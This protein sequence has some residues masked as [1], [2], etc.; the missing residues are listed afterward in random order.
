MATVSA[1][2]TSL[3]YDLRDYSEHDF[4][5]P[6]LIEYLNR[7]I[8]QLDSALLSMDSDWLYRTGTAVLSSGQNKITQPT[9][10]ISIRSMWVSSILESYT[11]LTFAASG[12]TIT[13]AALADFVDDGFVANQYIGVGG[14]TYNDTEDIGVLTLKSVAT[15]VLTVNENLIVDEG[16]GNQSATIFV[17][18]RE[19][20]INRARNNIVP[21]R[22]YLSSDSRPQSWSHEGTNI[23][24]D[25]IADEDYGI[26]IHFNG[27]SAVLTSSSNM[28]YNDEFNEELR[29]A[30]VLIS[31]NRESKISDATML[32]Y[33]TFREAATTKMV[34]RN[35]I[36]KRYHLDF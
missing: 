22:K 1:F 4:P 23:L 25:Y 19:S 9:G 18:D 2:F 11:D 14:T 34:R 27:K 36:P 26:I 17:I 12:D 21:Q 33:E 10:C 29:G 24:F 35:F 13:S 32:L 15:T 30:V 31:E 6:E 8:I 5:G 7:A 16:S 3:R 20:V 28:P